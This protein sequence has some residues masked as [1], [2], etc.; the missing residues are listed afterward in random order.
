MVADEEGAP[1]EVGSH[2]TSH[3]TRPDTPPSKAEVFEEFKRQRGSEINKVFLDNKCKNCYCRNMQRYNI[4]VYTY[5]HYCIYT[6]DFESSNI[7]YTSVKIIS[8]NE[9]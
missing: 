7:M 1:S 6:H 9:G 8:I 2:V 3:V 4:H 5:M